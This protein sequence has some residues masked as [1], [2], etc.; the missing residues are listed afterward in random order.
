MDTLQD[1][2]VEAGSYLRLIDS[3]ITQ[4]QDE[5]PSRTCNESKEEEEVRGSPRCFRQVSFAMQRG[6]SDLSRNKAERVSCRALTLADQ[7]WVAICN[8]HMRESSLNL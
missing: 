7:S 1:Q 3:C 4:L 5:R 6:Q 2:S 8:A